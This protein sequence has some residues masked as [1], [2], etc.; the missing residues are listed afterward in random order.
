M[1][2]TTLL[3]AK[4]ANLETL[5]QPLPELRSALEVLNL[6]RDELQHR[7]AVGEVAQGQLDLIGLHVGAILDGTTITVEITGGQEAQEE[8]ED[9]PTPEE[10]AAPVITLASPVPDVLAQET[11]IP[12]TEAD[13]PAQVEPEDEVPAEPAEQ[14]LVEP[15]TSNTD[16]V[17]AHLADHAGLSAQQLGQALGVPHKTISGMMSKLKLQGRV[18][19]DDSWPYLWSLTGAP[20]PEAPAPKVLQEAQRSLE[21]VR[22]PTQLLENMIPLPDG[23]AL[24][25]RTVFD[26]L[27]RELEGLTRGVLISRLNWS[28]GRVDRAA[29]TLATAGHIKLRGNRF[30]AVPAEMAGEVAS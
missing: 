12:K 1:S 17:L 7:I 16:R 10:S 11:A 15:G 25:E 26:A 24:D 29:N 13:Q 27:R 18:E 22:P 14:Q 23:L 3:S 21:K 30:V 2:H 6:Q 20:T 8:T 4:I 9:E 28:T 19:H 5:V